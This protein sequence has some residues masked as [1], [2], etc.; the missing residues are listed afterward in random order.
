MNSVLLAPT[1]MWLEVLAPITITL[2][3]IRSDDRKYRK[4]KLPALMHR[5]TVCISRRLGGRRCQPRERTTGY[6]IVK[7][8]RSSLSRCMRCWAAEMRWP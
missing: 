8:A 4:G 5:L 7:C 3:S 2:A 1:G 6:E